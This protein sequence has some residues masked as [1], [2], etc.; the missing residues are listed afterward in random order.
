MVINIDNIKTTKIKN[1]I[2][3]LSVSFLRLVCYLKYQIK[4]ILNFSLRGNKYLTQMFFQMQYLNLKGKNLDD[5]HVVAISSC[6]SK[7]EKLSGIKEIRLASNSRVKIPLLVEIVKK[8]DEPVI[9]E[10]NYD[11]LLFLLFLTT[12]FL[13]IIFCSSKHIALNL[14]IK[15]Y[16]RHFQVYWESSTKTI[17][18]IF[19]HD[20][21]EKKFRKQ[22]L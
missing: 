19:L 14:Y 8:M 17:C 13:I 1:V 22:K 2:F 18:K 21:W 6:I 4:H 20:Y 10:T 12:F 7:I 5:A 3:S 11:Y 16:D 15:N 9:M